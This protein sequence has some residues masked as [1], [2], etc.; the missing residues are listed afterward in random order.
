MKQKQL[1]L[2]LIVLLPTLALLPET[3]RTEHVGADRLVASG[4]AAAS[5]QHNQLKQPGSLAA[6]QLASFFQVQVPIKA[7]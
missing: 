4:G 5:I 1:K 7:K 3:M 6:E 2:L